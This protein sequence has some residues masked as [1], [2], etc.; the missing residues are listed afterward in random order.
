ME[1]RHGFAG[2]RQA[3]LVGVRVA[4]G[5]VAGQRFLQVRGGAEAEGAGVADVQAD[6]VA[7]LAF[8]FAGAAGQFTADVVADLAKAFAGGQG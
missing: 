8:E 2:Q 4:V 3:L 5:H 1:L 7:A 6:Q